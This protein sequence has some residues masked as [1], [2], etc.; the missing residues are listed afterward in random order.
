MDFGVWLAPPKGEMCIRDRYSAGIAEW[1]QQLHAAQVVQ[2]HLGRGVDRHIR[3]RLRDEPGQPQILHDERIY[4]R[5]TGGA[6]RF[7]SGGK[8]PVEHQGIDRQMD[9]STV[10][11]AERY[12]LPQCFQVK[13]LGPAAGVK[14][15][16][17]KINRVG[18]A[19]H[20]RGQLLLSLIHI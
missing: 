10:Y 5:F 18:A 20:R 11:M 7:H 13:I 1:F 3:C 17:A 16:H 4:P 2:A 12:G 9:A 14:I 19:K 6:D 15:S 8:L